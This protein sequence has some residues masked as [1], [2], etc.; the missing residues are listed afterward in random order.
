M[1][2]ATDKTGHFFSRQLARPN[3]PRW[4][5]VRMSRPGAGQRRRPRCPRP[6]LGWRARAFPIKAPIFGRLR[7]AVGKRG[8]KRELRGE[9]LRPPTREMGEAEERKPRG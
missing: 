5:G 8:Q 3:H 2:V 9:C 4:A 6:E 1:L 7:G